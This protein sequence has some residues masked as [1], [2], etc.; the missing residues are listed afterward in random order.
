MA[1][2]GGARPPFKNDPGPGRREIGWDPTS[3][4][5]DEEVLPEWARDYIRQMREDYEDVYIEEDPN[6]GAI[7]PPTQDEK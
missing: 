1:E 4:Y 6:A 2:K 3:W 7:N 5:G